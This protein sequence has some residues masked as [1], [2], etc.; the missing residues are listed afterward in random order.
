MN[1]NQKQCLPTK[2]HGPHPAAWHGIGH[3]GGKHAHVPWSCCVPPGTDQPQ[4]SLFQERNRILR[5]RERGSKVRWWW[6][7]IL[8]ITYK[9]VSRINEVLTGNLLPKTQSLFSF[10]LN[11]LSYR[12]INHI[13]VIHILH[14]AFYFI[15]FCI[16]VDSDATGR[17]LI[18]YSAFF[19]WRKNGNTMKQCITSL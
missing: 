12:F 9:M 1:N 6:S 15:L 8:P 10:C 4:E 11:V 2:V 19:K 14:F 17:L 16:Y 3:K 18:T 13:T 5:N 7:T